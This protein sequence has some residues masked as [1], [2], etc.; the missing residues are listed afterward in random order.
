MKNSIKVSIMNF[1]NFENET[2]IIYPWA[3]SAEDIITK[4]IDEI[5]KEC[6]GN[7]DT[8]IIY[9][10]IDKICGTNPKIND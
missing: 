1:V 8:D 9:E 5:E 4:H 10:A 7:N 2:S 6:N 3:I